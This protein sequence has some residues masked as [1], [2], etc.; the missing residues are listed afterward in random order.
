[1]RFKVFICCLL[2]FTVLASTS[3]NKNDDDSVDRFVGEYKISIT[4]NFMLTYSGYGTYNLTTDYPIETDCS[5]TNN[6]NNVTVKI[7]GINGVLNDIVI[8]GRCDGLGMRLNDSDYDGFIR[9]NDNDY[10][11]CDINLRNPNVSSP[12][13]GTMSWESSVSGSCR[14]DIFGMGE[15]V[16][17]DV[18]GKITFVA[19][20]K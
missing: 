10:V 14:V 11:R 4:P 17:C 12:Y 5:I 3:C 15:E 9:F 2:A 1:M 7:K 16:L 6:D 18:S 13:N 20:E 19:N 8:S